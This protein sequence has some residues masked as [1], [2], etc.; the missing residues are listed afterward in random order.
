MDSQF[1][2]AIE[3]GGGSGGGTYLKKVDHWEEHGGRSL[4]GIGLM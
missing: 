2:D 1:D 4:V 3:R